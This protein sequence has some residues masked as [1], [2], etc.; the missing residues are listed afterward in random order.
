MTDRR[1]RAVRDRRGSPDAF[2]AERARSG[3]TAA[4]PRRM[5]AAD[6]GADPDAVLRGEAGTLRHWNGLLPRVTDTHP[7]RGGRPE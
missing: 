3:A 7:E 2:L 6:F 4:E 1:P 5:S